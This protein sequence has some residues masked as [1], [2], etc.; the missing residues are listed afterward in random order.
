MFQKGHTPWLKGTKGLG[1]GGRKKG[2][3]PWNKGKKLSSEHKKHAIKN[4][5]QGR[6][7]GR[8]YSAET[9]KRMAEARLPYIPR[10]EKHWNWKGGITPKSFQ[11]RNS[12]EYKLWRKAVFERD[13]WTCIWCGIRGVELHADHIK[14]FAL[15]PELRFSIDNGRTLCVPCHKKTDTYFWKYKRIKK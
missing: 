10:K 6:L 12:K 14:P 11:I 7:P 1:K 3:I 4:L 15:F 13:N 5:V 9:R 8:K 2:D